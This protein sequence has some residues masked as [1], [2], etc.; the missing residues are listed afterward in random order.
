MP[1]QRSIT[2]VLLVVIIVAFSFS[3]LRYQAN[4]GQ[5]DTWFNT[6]WRVR[7]A[8]H[9]LVRWVFG[10]HQAGDGKADY[11]YPVR[12]EGFPVRIFLDPAVVIPNGSIDAALPEMVKLLG[13]G[14][15]DMG[16]PL[17]LTSTKDVYTNADFRSLA[18]QASKMDSIQTPIDIFILTKDSVSASQLGST[19]RE[20]GIVVFMGSIQELTSEPNAQ[21]ALVTSTILHEF[22]HQVGLDHMDNPTCIMAAVV[23][24][25]TSTVWAP[26]TVPTHY[27]AEELA[28]IAALQQAR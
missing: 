6:H 15:F 1:H 14:G 27:C 25:P 7:A 26:Q 18:A 10:L 3:I 17:Q 4:N 21:A 11:L 2:V 28:Q 8:E 5:Q 20:H 19:V 9:P 24:Q 12:T 23:E 22:G 13:S 16:T